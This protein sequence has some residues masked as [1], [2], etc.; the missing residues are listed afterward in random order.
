MTKISLPVKY[1]DCTPKV[2][3]QVRE[4][5]VEEQG[6]KCWYCNYSL[7]GNPDSIVMEAKIKTS[8]FPR[9]FFANPVHLHHNRRTGLTIGAVHARCNAHAW[10]YL[11]Q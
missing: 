11:G 5:Y 9:G 8:L 3:R 4:Q 1:D 6:G 2:R 10:Q 7:L